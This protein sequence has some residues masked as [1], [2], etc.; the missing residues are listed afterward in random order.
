VEE[1]SDSELSS[2]P[3]VSDVYFEQTQEQADE[4]KP[5]WRKAQSDILA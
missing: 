3:C 4:E 2:C 5:R 1:S